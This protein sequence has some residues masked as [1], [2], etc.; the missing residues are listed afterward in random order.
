MMNFDPIITSLLISLSINFVAYLIAFVLQTDKLTDGTYAL[1]FIA[2][3]VVLLQQGEI[4]YYRLIIALLVLLWALRLGSYLVSRI[5]KKGR[6]VRFD[7]MRK[8]WWRFGGFWLLQTLSIWVISLPF[9]IALGQSGI[10]VH[11]ALGS[12]ALTIGVITFILGWLIEWRADAQKSRHKMKKENQRK[13]I[14]TGL[15]KWVRFPNYL[16]EILI[17][18]GIFIA[19]TPVLSGWQWLS[20]ISPMWVAILLTKISGIPLLVKV[21]DKKYGQMDAYKE[22]I[23]K[24]KKLIPGIY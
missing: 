13:F 10:N 20:R 18:F 24:T 3:A 17:W 15:Y 1:S 19:C 23:A 11:R 16:G 6:D 9:V 14:S 2:I 7:A 4:Q 22:Y 5:I 8:V 12:P 21:Q